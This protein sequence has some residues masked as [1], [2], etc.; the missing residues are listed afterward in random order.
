M[1]RDNWRII[2]RGKA[3]WHAKNGEHVSSSGGFLDR[4]PWMGDTYRTYLDGAAEGCIVYDAEHA[5]DDAF[6]RLII[7]G[8]M[9][10]PS[11]APDAVDRFSDRYGAAS[12]MPGLSGSFAT[13]AALAQS[14]HYTGLDYVGIGVYRR[15]LATVPG[16]RLGTVR[17]GA[18][19]WDAPIVE[20]TP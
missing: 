11:L 10:E 5:D 17:N 7:S 8:P 20:V 9:V 16:M 13:I 2:G 3:G 1:I 6:A 19:V 12:M 18:V 15:L 4:L 14:D